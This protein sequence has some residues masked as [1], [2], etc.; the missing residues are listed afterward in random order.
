MASRKERADNSLDDAKSLLARYYP[1]AHHCG[2]VLFSVCV[3][4]S[5]GSFIYLLSAGVLWR[6]P[7]SFFS[8]EQRLAVGHASATFCASSREEF[9]LPVPPLVKM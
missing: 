8:L 4:F 6:L 7:C 1:S 5:F 9:F 3:C 2:G